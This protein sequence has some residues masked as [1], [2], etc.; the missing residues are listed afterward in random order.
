VVGLLAINHAEGI[1]D[2]APISLKNIYLLLERQCVIA[3]SFAKIPDDSG[4]IPFVRFRDGFGNSDA[5]NTAIFDKT[6]VDAVVAEYH[7]YIA[8][9]GV[10]FTLHWR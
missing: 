7:D 4:T 1:H 3:H 10:F 8:G 6:N 9:Y 5:T 2:R